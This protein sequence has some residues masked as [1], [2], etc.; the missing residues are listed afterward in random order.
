MS[1]ILENAAYVVHETNYDDRLSY[2][3]SLPRLN[4]STK[5]YTIQGHLQSR[6]LLVHN[7]IESGTMVTRPDIGNRT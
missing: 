2:T 3:F 1:N 7:Q 6:N 5:N 4:A